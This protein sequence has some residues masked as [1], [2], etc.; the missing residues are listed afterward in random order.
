[1]KNVLIKTSLGYD[2]VASITMNYCMQL[3]NDYRFSFLISDDPS[4]LRKDYIDFIDSKGWQIYFA[5]D[6][7]KS[8]VN[9]VK[10]LI[11]LLKREYFDIYHING[12][13]SLMFIDVAISKLFSHKTKI[14]TH[15]HNSDSTHKGLHVIFKPLFGIF[16]VKRLACSELAGNWAY[17]FWNKY[18]VITNGIHYDKFRFSENNRGQIRNAYNIK[19]QFVVLH[20]G[21]F[22]HQKNHSFMFDFMKDV[23][24]SNNN[25]LFVLIGDGDERSLFESKITREGLEGRIKCIGKSQEVW[26]WYSAAD[27]FVLP[28]LYEGLPVVLIEAQVSGL[29]CFVSNTVTKDADISNNITYMGIGPDDIN[30]WVDKIEEYIK[31]PCNRIEV[32]SNKFNIE[33]SSK[34][35][36][37]A[38]E[39]K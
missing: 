20:V 1:M 22:I 19:D 5:P 36:K 38:Y 6:P 31:T 13:S 11:S 17:C 26:K 9:Y 34:E 33:N 8:V 39:I 23:C 14:L 21:A 32:V 37:E 30:Q 4:S 2:G 35:L 29:K 12:N 7:A 18:D 24:K 25:V 15:S 10:T 28:S 27:L 16:R 3:Q